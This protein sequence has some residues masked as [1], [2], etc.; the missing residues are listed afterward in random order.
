[1]PPLLLPPLLLPELPP[2][3]PPLLPPLPPLLLPLDP[4]LLLPC[5]PLL[6]PLALPLLLP[7]APPLPLPLAPPLLLFPPPELP[8]PL[9]PLLLLAV[10]PSSPVPKGP[11][12]LP[13]LSDAHAPRNNPAAAKTA[14]AGAVRMTFLRAPPTSSLGPAPTSV[15]PHAIPRAYV[16]PYPSH[17]DRADHPPIGAI[18][19]GR[20]V[21]SCVHDDA[22]PPFAE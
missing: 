20:C 11:P 10:P 4:P 8:L 18:M 7:L 13:V 3:D 16:T 19:S 15:A 2:L 12:S 17:P 6:L 22:R 21:A 1:L 14:K 9:D 5:P